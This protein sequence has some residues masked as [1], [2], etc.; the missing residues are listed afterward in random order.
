MKNDA[1]YQSSIRGTIGGVHIGA[2]SAA[3]HLIDTE[4]FGYIAHLFQRG[5]EG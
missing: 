3:W 4:W 2:E 5:G 1:I